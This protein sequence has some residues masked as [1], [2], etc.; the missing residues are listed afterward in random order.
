MTLG[1]LAFKPLSCCGRAED[2]QT[3]CVQPGQLCHQERPEEILD[4]PVERQQRQ[5]QHVRT[6]QYFKTTRINYHRVLSN[7]QTRLQCSELA[8][9][10]Q[11]ERHFYNVAGQ[12][13]NV[14][15]NLTRCMNK[16]FLDWLRTWFYFTHT[17]L[18]RSFGLNSVFSLFTGHLLS[19]P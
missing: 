8:E 5:S 14:F 18:T 12:Y 1:T 13:T 10:E 19:L 2:G 17:D 7:I 16:M 15:Y 3:D 6:W 9:T 11:T 4:I